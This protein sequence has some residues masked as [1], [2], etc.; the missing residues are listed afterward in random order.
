VTAD[1]RQMDMP[2]RTLDVERRGARARV[3]I[4]CGGRDRR[5][6]GRPGQPEQRRRTAKA[7]APR[8]V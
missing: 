3:T 8:P 4:W 5:S 6:A 7:R 2:R 1:E